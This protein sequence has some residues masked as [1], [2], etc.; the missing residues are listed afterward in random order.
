M[1]QYTPAILLGLFVGRVRQ[2]FSIVW[3]IEAAF[4]GVEFDGSAEFLGRPMI[5]LAKGSRIRVGDG[6]RIY[7]SVRA[8]PLGLA[9]PCVLRALTPQSELLLGKGVGIS[10]AVICAGARVEIGEKSIVGA[11][12]MVI[13]N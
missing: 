9:Q 7:S 3:R 12:A 4:K 1:R 13:D 6:V 11:G 2:S 8:N 10:G 5:S